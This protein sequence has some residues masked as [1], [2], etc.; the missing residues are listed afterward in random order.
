MYF[1]IL[2]DETNGELFL[3]NYP[4]LRH[5]SHIYLLPLHYARTS[6]NRFWYIQTQT[7]FF[8]TTAAAIS[9]ATVGA[10]HK[11]YFAVLANGRMRCILFSDIAGK[12][13]SPF[14]AISAISCLILLCK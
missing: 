8:T 12:D 7:F 11:A 5:C 14:D 1:K 3:L 13:R 9:D 2:Y 6:S 4:Y 10:S